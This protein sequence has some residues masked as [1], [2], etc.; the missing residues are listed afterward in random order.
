MASTSDNV[1]PLALMVCERFGG[2]LAMTNETTNKVQHVLLPFEPAPISFIKATVGFSRKDCATQLGK[3]AAGLRFLGLAAALVTSLGAFEGAKALELMLKSTTNDATF[4][5]TTRHLKEVLGSLEARSQRCGFSEL[6]ATWQMLLREAALPHLFPDPDEVPRNPPFLRTAPSVEAIA[7]LVDVFRQVARMGPATVTGATIKAGSAAPWVLAFVQ[8]CVEPPSVFL[9]DRAVVERPESRIRVVL[10]NDI[11]Q[12]VEITIHHQVK[13][14]TP[15]LLGPATFFTAATGMVAV[16]L[17][18][19]WLLPELGF[20]DGSL[21]LL[22]ES[23]QYAIPQVL[24]K[25]K[26][27]WFARLGQYVHPGRWPGRSNKWGAADPYCPSPLP[28]IRSI[29]ATCT[30]FLAFK[31]PI[32]FTMPDDII[33]IAE[34]PLVARHLASLEQNCQCEHCF[35]DLDEDSIPEW[36]TKERFFRSLSFII[37]DIFALSLFDS[38]STLLLRLSVDR[39]N[40]IGMEICIS[41]LIGIG[42][43]QDF[44]NLNIITWARNMVGHVLEEQSR[45]IISSSKGQV[46][47]PRVFDARHLENHGY[48]KLCCLPGVLRYQGETYDIVSYPVLGIERLKNQPDPV[49]VREPVSRPLNICRDFGSSWS[50]SVRDNGELWAALLLHSKLDGSRWIEKDPLLLLENMANTL[51]VDGCPHDPRAELERAD[52]F[53]SYSCPWED[54]PTPPPGT[55]SQVSVVAVDGADDLR[56]IALACTGWVSAVLGRNSCL[57]C[58]LNVCRDNDIHVLIL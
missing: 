36:C 47:Y 28:D 21:R 14:L 23:L 37:M 29:A 1:Q 56:C 58:C 53:A 31:D 39:E 38:P 3:S 42:S 20:G 35:P 24:R 34:L 57:S 10:S 55:S 17:Y 15:L 8:W 44:D 30:A 26:G 45:V 19:A 12:P 40:G 9:A 54:H 41:E 52:R 51:L 22:P 27:G 25:L 50:I 49:T 43:C 13:E 18:R 11:N 5:P 2:T 6:F 7:G 32:E 16:E 48:L 33:P 4:L 46:I